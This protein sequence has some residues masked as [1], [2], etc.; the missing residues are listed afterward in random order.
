VAVIWAASA[1]GLPAAGAGGGR[2]DRSAR[3]AVPA[4][5][6]GLCGIGGEGDEPCPPMPVNRSCAPGRGRSLP[7][8]HA[9]ARRSAVQSSSPLTSAVHAPLADLTFAVTGR[10]PMPVGTFGMALLQSS[11]IVIPDG[12]VLPP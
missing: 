10:R 5:R 7:H 1:G 8:D 12:A 4:P 3:G 9:H 2:T 11:V 6:A